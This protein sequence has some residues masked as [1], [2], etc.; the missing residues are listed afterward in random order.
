MAKAK[1]RKLTAAIAAALIEKEKMELEVSQNL[2]LREKQNTLP[3]QIK[4]ES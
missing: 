1:K 4:T 2:E 3:K